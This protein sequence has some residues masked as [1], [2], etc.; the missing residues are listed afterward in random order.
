MANQK[1]NKYD[2]FSDSH[3]NNSMMTAL[4][5][6]LIEARNKSIQNILP[7][8]REVNINWSM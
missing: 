1:T 7:I 6:R 5:G 8:L 3:E 2:M 4:A